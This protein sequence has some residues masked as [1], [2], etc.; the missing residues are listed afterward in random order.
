MGLD[1]TVYDK[2][3]EM[4][5]NFRKNYE[6]RN[7]LEDKYCIYPL[8]D[9]VKITDAMA[10]DILKATVK[11]NKTNRDIKNFDSHAF[12]HSDTARLLKRLIKYEDL[13][14]STCS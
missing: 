14:I 1:I 7:T 2:Q 3:N 4:V 12:S 9:N 5:A 8:E 6:I 13:Y 10:D 11:F